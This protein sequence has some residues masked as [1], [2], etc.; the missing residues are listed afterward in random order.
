[1][2]FDPGI[3]DA[4]RNLLP[5]LTQFFLLVTELGGELFYIG[6]LL[7]GYWAFN[8]R[9]SIVATYVLL[10]AVLSNYWLKYIIANDRPPA[11]YWVPGVETPNFSTPSGHAQNSATLF[12]WFS[13]RVKRWWMLVIGVVS[14]TLIGLSRVYLGVHY[15]DDV[16]LGWG[17]GIL[18]VI[19][20]Y[21][22]EKPVREYLSRFRF[23][24]LLL[25]VFV[26]GLIMTLIAAALTAPP[27]DNFGAL[28]GL[29]MGL[30]L[31]FILEA[32]YVNFTVD[33]PNGQ[34]WRLVLRVVI[35]LVFVLGIMLGLAGLLPTEDIF[36][37]TIRYFLVAFTGIFVWPLIFKKI[38]L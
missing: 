33:A 9:E 14:T 34:K 24:Y 27:N 32:R 37:R 20:I 8:K 31:G 15:L 2:F 6:L 18:T 35:G 25:A 13:V 11:S 22:F 21:Y 23:E 17:I 30:A 26:M 28:G 10:I 16:L 1:M 4:F 36:L 12:G 3:I 7:I 29:T 5:G 38:N 19:L